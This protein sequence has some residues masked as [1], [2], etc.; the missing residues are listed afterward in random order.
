MILTPNWQKAAVVNISSMHECLS[1][2]NNVYWMEVLWCLPT[3]AQGDGTRVPPPCCPFFTYHFISCS[4]LH[5]GRLKHAPVVIVAVAALR[6]VTL[7]L[8]FFRSIYL[9]RRVSFS[10]S[11]SPISG[12]WLW[13]VS[14]K[15]CAHV[16]LSRG[17]MFRGTSCWYASWSTYVSYR[18]QL[19]LPAKFVNIHPKILLFRLLLLYFELLFKLCC[20]WHWNMWMVCDW[21]LWWRECDVRL[22]SAFRSTWVSF[23]LL[24]SL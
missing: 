9:K 24:F 14:R 7:I 3:T 20:V 5:T 19:S 23:T 18:L 12:W 8:L 22:L 15:R 11:T 13:L 6:L 10:H 1:R 21:R 16:H 4:W 2:E 17:Y